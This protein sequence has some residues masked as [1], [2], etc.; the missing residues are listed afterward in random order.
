MMGGN[1]KW[2]QYRD[3]LTTTVQAKSFQVTQYLKLE[4]GHLLLF[5][6]LHLLSDNFSGMAQPKYDNAS[7]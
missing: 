2:T 7:F 1:K 6:W 3:L 4:I 5:S